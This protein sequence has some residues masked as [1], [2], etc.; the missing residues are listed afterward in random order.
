MN[1]R[2]LKKNLSTPDT[3]QRKKRGWGAAFARVF[4]SLDGCTQAP[5]DGFMV[6]RAKA[7]SQPYQ[8]KLSMRGNQLPTWRA[9]LNFPTTKMSKNTKHCIFGG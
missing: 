2:S 5:G 8:Y 7:V 3:Q 9:K 1:H 6:S 4:R